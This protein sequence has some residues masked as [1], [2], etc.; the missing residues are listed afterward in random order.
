[1][2][3][4]KQSI[5]LDTLRQPFKSAIVTAAEL[6]ATA[7]EIN[8]RT[9]VRAEQLSQTGIRHIRKMLSDLNLGVSAIHFQTNYGYGDLQMLDR[10]VEGTKATLK[11][12]YEL[13]CNVVVNRVGKIPPEP[14]DESWST[15]VQSLAD[16]GNYSQKAGAWLAARTGADDG[17][18]VKGLIDSLPIQSLMIDF[19]PA[20]LLIN[21]HSPTDTMKLLAPQV[22]NCR[23][24]DAVTDFSLGRGIEVAMGQG[25]VDWPALLGLLEEQSYAGYLTAHRE[26]SQNP[27]GDCREAFAFLSNLFG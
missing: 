13:G 8:G 17:E 21:G 7:V 19:D 10:R 24:R 12:A 14:T 1:M 6:G 11:L 3:K 22:V 2:L 26:N 4:L 16:I 18:T 27:I 20:E 25:A 9:E 23:A 15:M 5:F